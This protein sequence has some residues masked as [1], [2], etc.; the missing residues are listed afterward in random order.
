M[1]P[2]PPCFPVV[3]S[4]NIHQG[5]TLQEVAKTVQRRHQDSRSVSQDL[6]T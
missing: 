1:P 6:N 4:N 2:F 5:K 3:R